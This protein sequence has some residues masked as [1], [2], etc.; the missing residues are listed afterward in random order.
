MDQNILY[1]CLVEDSVDGG[2]DI[3]VGYQLLHDGQEIHTQR[4]RKPFDL[5]NMDTGEIR[6][7]CN[8]SIGIQG[9]DGKQQNLYLGDISNS[10]LCP[11][12]TCNCQRDFLGAWPDRLWEKYKELCGV[13]DSER[14]VRVLPKY[15]DGAMSGQK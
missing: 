10:G 9:S 2:R 3:F 13:D 11:C 14:K 5:A 12:S 1:C 15:R 7:Q 6:I 8:Q 4:F